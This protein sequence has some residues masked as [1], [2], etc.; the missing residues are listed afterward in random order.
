MA[1]F[2]MLQKALGLQVVKIG[3]QV[4]YDLASLRPGGTTFLLQR[5]EDAENGET[6]GKVALE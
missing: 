6:E 2:Q 5:L 3:G 1:R 4:P